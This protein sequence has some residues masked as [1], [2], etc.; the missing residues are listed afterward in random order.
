MFTRTVNSFGKMSTGKSYKWTLRHG[1]RK[2][3]CPQ[4]GKR[5]FVPYVLAADG[6]TMAGPE[7]GRCDREQNCGYQR[8][9]S[10][11]KAKDVT[12]IVRMPEK[13]LRFYPAAVRVDVNTNL[14][15]YA[16]KLCG[17]DNAMRIW[18]RYKIGRD[19][20][21]TVFWQISA[22]GSIRAGK[23]IPYKTDGHRDKTDEYPANWLHK[24]P[25]WREMYEGKELQQCYF[26]EHLLKAHEQLPVVIVESEKTAAIMSEY[27]QSWVWLASGGSQGLKNDEKNAALKGRDVWLLPDNGQYW[28]WAAT[29]DK[30]G[31]HI[32]DTL[33]KC[34]LFE[35]CDILDL[36]EAGIFGTELIKTH[37]W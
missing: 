15:V 8:Y 27:S 36:L 33:E 21:R 14:F 32:F 23:S 26:G 22:D 2:E 12:P 29:A 5:R 34:K 28:N 13:P 7:Y 9:P 19:G 16:S 20:N 10:D 30:N 11:V 4:C 25:F 35:G 24:S 37:L 18:Q 17:T 1:S 3:I 6:E 31:W